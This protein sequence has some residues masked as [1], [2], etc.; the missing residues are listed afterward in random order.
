MADVLI[1][2]R[3][4]A[5][6]MTSAQHKWRCLGRRGPGP[7]SQRRQIPL[8]LCSRFVPIFPFPKEEGRMDN[9]LNRIR[10]EMNLLREEMRRAE[11]VMHDRIARDRDST[12]AAVR[13]L[14]LR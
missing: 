7:L 13:V 6:V 5:R 12:E 14:E 8:T 10:K 9:R 1:E 3:S 4:L 2:R 11:A